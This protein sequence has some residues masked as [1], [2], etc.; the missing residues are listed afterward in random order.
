V[1]EEGFEHCRYRIPGVP[2]VELSVPWSSEG[3][4]ALP[5]LERPTID[6]GQVGRSC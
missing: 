3:S 4:H 5:R 2:G 1:F 6:R